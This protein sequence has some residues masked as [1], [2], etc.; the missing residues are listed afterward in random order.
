MNKIRSG[1][2]WMKRNP[3]QKFTIVLVGES[4]AIPPINKDSGAVSTF[5]P[6]LAITNDNFLLLIFGNPAIQNKPN[7]NATI[8]SKNP[9]SKTSK[10]A[11]SKTVVNPYSYFIP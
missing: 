9:Y 1:I 6:K 2:P 10:I 5:N 11:A 4:V 3:V 8:A 7:A